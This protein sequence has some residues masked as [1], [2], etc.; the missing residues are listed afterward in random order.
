MIIFYLTMLALSRRFALDILTMS[1]YQPKESY[2]PISRQELI[3]LCLEDGNLMGDKPQQFREFCQILAA[4]YHFCYHEHFERIKDNFRPFNPESGFPSQLPYYE[5]NQRQRELIGDFLNILRDG[6]Y[7]PLSRPNLQ[8]A[9]ARNSLLDLQTEVDFDDFEYFYCFARGD[10][11]GK[12]P[13]NQYGRRLMRTVDILQETI[14]L[15]KFKSEHY[16]KEKGRKIS[17]LKFKPGKVY[18]YLYKDLAKSDLGFIFPNVVSRMTSRDSL[19][20][21]LPATIAVSSL[22]AKILPQAK[23]LLGILILSALGNQPWEILQVSE[24]QLL[25]FGPV[26]LTSFTMTMALGSFAFR[27]YTGY[28]QKLI[29][30]QK[31]ASDNLFFSNVASNLGVFQAL[32]DAAEEEECKEIILVYYHLLAS[33]RAFTPDLLD[34]YIEEWMQAR[35]GKA[36]DFDLENT[37]TSLANIKANI[38]GHQLSLLTRDQLNHC[39]PLPLDRAK[40][41]LDCIWDHIFLYNN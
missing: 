32:I 31:R 29:K 27:Q 20:F 24:R 30:F 39:Q 28:K 12:R 40:Q 8:E 22:M 10:V 41:V 36:I 35:L 26:M 11:M 6:N 5:E 19:I 16:F 17:Q 14:L 34:K 23:L 9:I 33:R 4:Y 13:V 2:I 18:I 3:E 7:Q 1:N 21:G 38:E 25:D 15:I 37:L